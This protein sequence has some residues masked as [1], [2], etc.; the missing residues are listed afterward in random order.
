M[1]LSTWAW[2]FRGATVYNQ[3][4]SDGARENKMR[5]VI[6]GSTLNSKHFV[7]RQ[8]LF[9]SMWFLLHSDY[10]DSVHDNTLLKLNSG[11]ES[12]DHV[13]EN[14]L[15][16]L[17][18][19]TSKA[20]QSS[21]ISHEF[22]KIILY[23]RFGGGILP[24]LVMSYLCYGYWGWSEDLVWRFHVIGLQTQS[25]KLTQWSRKKGHLFFFSLTVS[26]SVCA[27]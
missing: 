22:D 25:E 8:M 24:Y 10:F 12:K 3:V 6:I 26:S 1:G 17:Y 27:Q 9:S 5:L 23:F 16:R 11:F 18:H 19:Q 15:G 21:P 4:N 7:K 14:L 20:C 2:S 13:K